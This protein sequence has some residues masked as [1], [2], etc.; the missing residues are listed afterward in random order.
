[1]DIFQFFPLYSDESLNICT[2]DSLVWYEAQY[3]L[4]SYD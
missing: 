2:I 4:S 1:M 3:H